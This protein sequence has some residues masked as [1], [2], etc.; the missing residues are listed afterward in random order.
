MINPLPS[1]VLPTSVVQLGSQANQL[2]IHTP[3][4]AFGAAQQQAHQQVRQ[5]SES[6]SQE[7]LSSKPFKRFRKPQEASDKSARR[8]P[9]WTPPIKQK[10]FRKHKQPQPQP[11]KADPELL[12]AAARR[13]IQQDSRQQPAPQ[14]DNTLIDDGKEGSNLPTLSTEGKDGGP[15]PAKLNKLIIAAASIEDILGLYAVHKHGF[16]VINLATAFYRMARVSLGSIPALT[17]ID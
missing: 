13:V 5:I 8:Q 17:S 1:K 7:A 16:N 4:R 14:H 9:A 15:H 11:N 6:K 10:Q 2:R 12:K 3:T